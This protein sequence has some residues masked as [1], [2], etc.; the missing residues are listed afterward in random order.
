MQLGGLDVT[1]KKHTTLL[2]FFGCYLVSM[3]FR[4]TFGVSQFEYM[5]CL[6]RGTMDM[7]RKRLV[8]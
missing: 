3:E 8:D 2:F 6:L 7:N 5:G 4:N 1:G